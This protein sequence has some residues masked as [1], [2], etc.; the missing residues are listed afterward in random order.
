MSRKSAP[1]SRPASHADLGEVR[2]VADAPRRARAHR[3][4]LG[5]EPPRAPPAQRLGQLQVRR[6]HD[7]RAV[8]AAR[9]GPRR[10][11][12]ASPSGRSVGQRERRAARPAGRRPSAGRTGTSACDDLAAAAAG[13][14]VELDPDLDGVAVRDVHR[15]VRLAALADDEH[16]RQH[17]APRHVLDVGDARG[18]PA[19]ATTRRRRARRARPAAWRRDA[20]R[21]LA[22]EVPVVGDHAVGGREAQQGVGRGAG[23]VCHTP[24]LPEPHART[25]DERS[26]LRH[27]RGVRPPRPRHA[28]TVAATRR[29][30]ADHDRTRSAHV[31]AGP[32]TRPRRGPARSRG[33]RPVPRARGR[34]CRRDRGVVARAGRPV[35]RATAPRSAATARSRPRP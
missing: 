1:S 4:Q 15:D 30:L 19:R 27:S 5:H 3:V 18:R 26:R 17:A 31:P 29:S 25:Q 10:R 14:G 32:S 9:S 20:R 23:V 13:L 7:E 6:R 11:S 35:R 34:G 2:Q 28:P 16:G 21:W 33:R 24:I 22:V 12:R 8:R